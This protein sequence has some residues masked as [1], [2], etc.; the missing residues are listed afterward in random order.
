MVVFM[1]VVC[2]SLAQVSAV[3]LELLQHL[4][5]QHAAS[6]ELEELLLQGPAS[7]ALL[8]AVGRSLHTQP[9]LFQAVAGLCK[10][11]AP[12]L[13]VAQVLCVCVCISICVCVLGGATSWGGGGVAH[14]PQSS[15]EV[16]LPRQ[17]RCT[18]LRGMVA[19]QI[20]TFG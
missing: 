9:S 3:A 6:R 2:W 4:A 14:N 16:P 7:T 13:A 20:S 10:V 12:Y 5:A 18:P 11:R 15:W 8:T 19:T 17:M 1:P